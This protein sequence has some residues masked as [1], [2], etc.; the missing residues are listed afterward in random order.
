MKRKIKKNGE[1][2]LE[3]IVKNGSVGDVKVEGEEIIGDGNFERME[4]K[5][6]MDE[7]EYEWREIKE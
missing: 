3:L 6:M 4:I 1:F 2:E 5:E 7:M